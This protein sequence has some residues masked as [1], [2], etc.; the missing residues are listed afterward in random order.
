M[1]RLLDSSEQNTAR[2][3]VGDWE[4]LISRMPKKVLNIII[5]AIW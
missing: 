1:A 4:F 5:I 3:E 2:I